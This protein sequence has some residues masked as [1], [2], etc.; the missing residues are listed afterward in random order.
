MAP[1][2]QIELSAPVTGPLAL[3]RLS[4]FGLGLRPSHLMKIVASVEVA[5]PLRVD[6]RTQVRGHFRPEVGLSDPPK[7]SPMRDARKPWYRPRSQGSESG[8]PDSAQPG[9]TPLRRE[10]D[11]R[12]GRIEL[13][14]TPPNLGGAH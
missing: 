3:G 13:D 14:L 1:C 5:S 12:V 2:L 7:R 10:H 11:K 6:A 9:R 8:S 4:H